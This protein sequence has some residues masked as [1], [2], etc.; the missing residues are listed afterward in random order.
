MKYCLDSCVAF[1]WAVTEADADK[2]DRLRVDFQ[3]GVHELI[4]PD[5]FHVEVAHALTRAERQNRIQPPHGW[6]AWLNI[7]ADCPHFHSS[8]LLM[9]RAYAI[10]SGAR[11]GV[12]DCL[13]VA[14]PSVKGAN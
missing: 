4:A 11:I 8:H 12:Y 3:N 13:Y 2:A 5:I 9:P 14:W 7:M 10:S 6:T 1:K